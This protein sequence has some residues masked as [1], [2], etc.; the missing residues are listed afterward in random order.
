MDGYQIPLLFKN[1]LAYLPCR[2]PTEEEIGLLPHVVMT[3]DVDWDPS[4]Y[5]NVIEDMDAFHDPTLDFIDHDNPFNEYGEYRNCTIAMHTLIEGEEEFFVACTFLDF[6]DMVDDLLDTLHP[7]KV[8]NTY[9]ISL[10]TV[11]HKANFN[12]LHPLFGWAPAETLKKTIEVTT[13]FAHGRVS[14]TLKQH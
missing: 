8:N 6:H 4:L 7:D 1:G 13:Q 3:S 10:T 14:D 12:L 5:D 11:E 2:N 9:T